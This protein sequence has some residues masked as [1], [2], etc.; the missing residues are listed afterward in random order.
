MAYVRSMSGLV[1]KDVASG[2]N[3]DMQV[4]S[5]EQSTHEGVAA[6][7]R[8]AQAGDAGATAVNLVQHSV[9]EPAGPHAALIHDALWQPMYVVAAVDLRAGRR[10]RSPGR[11][12]GGA[13]P[14]RDRTIRTAAR[15]ASA[16]PSVSP[17]SRRPWCC[18]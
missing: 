9:L 12:S 3:D 15:L 4:R 7:E 8:A 6:T 2:R 5:Q 16:A 14:T 17:R 13:A 1:A 18:S 11:C 10:R